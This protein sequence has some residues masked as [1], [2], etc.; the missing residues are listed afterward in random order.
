MTETKNVAIDFAHGE[1]ALTAPLTP[2]QREVW[3]A[4]QLGGQ[5]ANL[6]YNEGASLTLRG[7]LDE[8]ALASAL[9]ALVSRHEALRATFSADG[10]SILFAPRGSLVA[11][12]IAIASESEWA[13]LLQREA[14][15]PFDLGRGPLLRA[16]LAR[17][18]ADEH[19][20]LIVGHHLVL[21][22]G[23]F[24]VLLEE[25]GALYDAAAQGQV[26]GLESAASY[27]TYARE[28][29]A[30][31]RGGA[32]TTALGFWTQQ[33][34]DG[35][36]VLELPV[37]R[38]R[39]PLRTYAA[40]RHDHA[41]PA[42]LCDALRTLAKQHDTSLLQVL[43]TG[44]QVALARITNQWDLVVGV[45]ASAARERLVGHAISYLPIRGKLEPAA[46]FAVALAKSKTGLV[47]ALANQH[48]SFGS[49]LSE[50]SVPRDPSRMPLAPVS[51]NLEPG[52][53]QSGFSGLRVD[54]HSLPRAFDV[55]EI[56]ANLVEHEHE[57]VIEAQFNRDLF[58]LATIRDWLC[59]YEAV[60][61]G[62]VAD[63]QQPLQDLPVLTDALRQRVLHDWNATETPYAEHTPIHGFF[64]QQASA[65]PER[66]A[67]TFEGTSL[68]YGELE[69]RANQVAN[70]L[71]ARGVGPEQIV[72]VCVR[73]SSD[74][75]VA[76]LGV[77]KA[78]A[79]YLPLDPTYPAERIAYMLDDSGASFVVSRTDSIGALGTLDAK[80]TPVLL[81]REALADSARPK[82]K[83]TPRN[84]AY[85]IY[86]SG[87]T[88]KP[89]GVLVEHGNFANFLAGMDAS[90]SLASPGVW[91]NATSIGFDISL[92]EIFGSL[93]R[94]FTVIVHNDDSP[95]EF[96]LAPLLAQGVTHFQCT[97][98]Q[99]T[100]LISDPKGAQALAGLKELLLGGEAMPVDLAKQ[101]LA[102]LK[103]GRLINMY[104]PTETTIWSTTHAVSQP[105]GSVPIG[106]PIANTRIYILDERGQPAPRGAIGE[107]LIGGAGVTRGYHQRPELTESRFV[108]DPF[109]HGRMYKTGDLARLRAD[110]AVEFLGRNDHQVKLRGYRIELGE[111]E[112][113][114]RTHSAVKEAAVIARE[115]RPGDKRLVA[116]LVAHGEP[117][118]GELR[119]FLTQA[120][121]PDYMLPQAF[122]PLAK[123]P[124][125]PNGKL[126]RRALPAP[127]QDSTLG[128]GAYIAPEGELEQ[129]VADAWCAVLGVSR[130]GAED[131]FFDLGGHSLLVVKLADAIAQRTGKQLAV[132]DLFRFPT[133][134]SLANFLR[135]GAS[136]NTGSAQRGT[137][138]AAAATRRGAGRR[139]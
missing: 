71:I 18:G 127:A 95:P 92:L 133:V 114:L 118:V 14:E 106:K 4:V 121:L 6:A 26:P 63:P 119:T 20:L 112:V 105:E 28:R 69:T 53:T 113:A 136:T 90:L 1:S 39:S 35:V 43:L 30:Q 110:G 132:P 31:E 109:A 98:S 47:D 58:E 41:L 104:G 60:L 123:L 34:T 36:P 88:G 78:G 65:H 124:T 54:V 40:Q 85:T 116:Y 126:D 5:P 51:F 52:Y 38:P 102:L 138:R 57:L 86:T 67:L 66:R 49:L 17:V 125:T 21:D 37:D 96:A 10:S 42:A 62:V 99:A 75:I 12:P 103:N 33:Y 93:A 74:M 108:A 11:R 32:Y 117:T 139:G 101:L 84:I 83:L 137:E 128:V 55:F 89:K 135:V 80:V 82:V 107:L 131:N 50:L 70:A 81:D 2:P 79:A 25:L 22:G 13:T 15:E 68:T 59:S 91:L 97:P 115:D 46:P 19:R 8:K 94:G 24:G 9:Q 129:G 77:L 27:V 72:G 73:R 120:G 134:K 61:A 87:S 130:V 16:T 45:Q 111:I 76:Q 23:S 48:V 44:F 100:L 122:V 29:A 7:A 64:E 56:F 3:A